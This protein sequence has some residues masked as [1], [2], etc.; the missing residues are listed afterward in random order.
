MSTAQTLVRTMAYEY[1]YSMRFS[2]AD[3]FTSTF[4]LFTFAILCTTVDVALRTSGEFAIQHHT[5]PCTR[6]YELSSI[7]ECGRAKVAL[8]PSRTRTIKEE[9][10][11]NAPRGCS[12][13]DGRW[14][15]NSHAT[16]KLDGASEP[17]CKATA[18]KPNDICVHDPC[19]SICPKY[20]AR[21]STHQ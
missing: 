11:P 21:A 2:F 9:T 10:I 3:C 4:R 18:G 5:K 14:Y 17:V 7:E 13:Y 8:D 15:F 20:S 12:R 6:T 1:T 19:I 16:G